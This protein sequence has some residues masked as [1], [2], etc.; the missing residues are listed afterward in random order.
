MKIKAEIV[1]QICEK[2]EKEDI[3][4]VVKPDGRKICC[5]CDF[6]EKDVLRSVVRIKVSQ[7]VYFILENLSTKSG[8]T[9]SSIIR[10][11][12]N[13][14]KNKSE[15]ISKIDTEDYSKKIAVKLNNDCS[16]EE[17]QKYANK[18]SNQD[19]IK[20]LIELHKM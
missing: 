7:E 10:E 15:F 1:K 16:V 19:I 18:I 5:D 17:Y 8:I 6:E 4:I 11:V 14:Y 2:C 3:G 20:I 13:S 12:L 9:K